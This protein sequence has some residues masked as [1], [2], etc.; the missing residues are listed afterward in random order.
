MALYRLD[1][2]DG[3]PVEAIPGIGVFLSHHM[4]AA[5]R[6]ALTRADLDGRAI[7][8]TRINDAGQLKPTLIVNP[9]GTCSKPPGVDGGDCRA[10]SGV[11]CFCANCRAQRRRS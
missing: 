11:T 5:R 8:I 10:E 6:F 9:D 1:Y 7:Q 2:V 4:M 3:E